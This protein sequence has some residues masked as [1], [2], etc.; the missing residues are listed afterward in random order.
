[1]FKAFGTL[2]CFCIFNDVI[3]IIRLTNAKDI[4]EA[5]SEALHT[6]VLPI[7]LSEPSIDSIHTSTHCCQNQR[8]HCHHCSFLLLHFS[9]TLVSPWNVNPRK[10]SLCDHAFHVHCMFHSTS[11]FC[12]FNWGICRTCG[13]HFHCNWPVNS[14]IQEL[15]V[16]EHCVCCHCCGPKVF[17]FC[18]VFTL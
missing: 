1:M 2:C 17:A 6:M 14:L 11:F 12:F 18:M 3:V 16:T 8:S 9:P 10:F 15:P 7:L 4:I 5:V 13:P